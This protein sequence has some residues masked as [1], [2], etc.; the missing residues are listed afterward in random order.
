MVNTHRCGLSS[1]FEKGHVSHR[2]L[3]FKL[4][5]DGEKPVILAVLFA[6]NRFSLHIRIINAMPMHINRRG[7]SLSV[8][9]SSIFVCALRSGRESGAPDPRPTPATAGLHPFDAAVFE[10]CHR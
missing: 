9:R 3:I 7:L 6:E 5:V 2:W 10:L 8:C 4:F 1:A